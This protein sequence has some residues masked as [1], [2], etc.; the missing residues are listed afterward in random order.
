MIVC[1]VGVGNTDVVD[2]DI[3]SSDTVAMY[4]VL[5]NR[6]VM[7]DSVAMSCIVM[8][9]CVWWLCRWYPGSC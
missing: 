3:H 8:C 1:D 4:V 7:Y 9:V 6:V 2:D 5:C